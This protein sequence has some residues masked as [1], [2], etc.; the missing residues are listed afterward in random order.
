M[1]GIMNHKAVHNREDE[2]V[3]VA[4]EVKSPENQLKFSQMTMGQY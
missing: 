4:H 1:Q 2:E 3:G